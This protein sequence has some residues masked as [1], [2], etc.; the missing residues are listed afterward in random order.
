MA[1]ENA[2]RS[3][4]AAFKM[5]TRLSILSVTSLLVL[6]LLA[7]LSAPLWAQKRQRRTSVPQQQQENVDIEQTNEPR[8]A[9]ARKTA[10]A[11]LDRVA[12]TLQ[13]ADS[14]SH[15][16][17][18]IY[19]LEGE[20][21]ADTKRVLTLAEALAKEK[22]VTVKETG[23]VN[24]LTV[25]NHD[26]KHTVFIMAGD[27]VKGG[28]QDRTLAT[29]LP[30]MT[31]SGPVPI[32]A[33]CVEQGRWRARGTEDVSTFSSSTKIVASKE[34]KIAIRSKKQQGEVWQ[35][36]AK[37]QEKIGGKIGKPIA[38]AASPTSLQLSLEDKD[39]KKKNDGYMGALREIVEK[40]E[41]S[42]GFVCLINGHIN[43]AEI[44]A[45]HDLF[46]RA[47]P[48]LLEAAATEAIAE[49]N[50][51]PADK[52]ATAETMK[53]FLVASE[54]TTASKEQIHGSYWSV[55][56]ENGT[57]FIFQ[58]INDAIDYDAAD[59]QKSAWL[60]RSVLKK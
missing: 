18:T 52:S 50:E 8:R 16:N 20:D 36:V 13:V 32:S 40:S 38:A 33:F 34:G 41:R 23:N 27:I 22:T 19:L 4:V 31:K 28:K 7:S 46:R 43:S 35:S 5:K 56:G 24:E 58:T 26:P 15:E 2:R 47:W 51:K 48:K 11:N 44:F 3:T 57:A 45:G 6:V 29:D 10:P 30:L 12:E 54:D 25:E 1:R 9:P 60:R 21:R 17:L 49:Q 42:I 14:K 53:E 59:S 55:T 39:L 37:T